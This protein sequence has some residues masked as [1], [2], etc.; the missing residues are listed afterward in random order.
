MTA[1]AGCRRIGRTALR[2]LRHRP[3]A[4]RLAP[5]LVGFTFALTV[6]T[7][8]SGC[9]SS[10]AGTPV[11]PGAGDTPP[12]LAT[13]PAGSSDPSLVAAAGL[14]RCP[15]TSGAAAVD[16]G[17]PDVTL[18]CLA[19]GPPVRLSG[20]RG[21]PTLVN[22]WAS[23]CG[24]CRGELP[25]L[26]R[27]DDAGLR[28][29]GVDLLDHPDAALATLEALDITYPSVQ[30]PGGSLRAELGLVATP[31]TLFVAPDGQIVHV[32]L[33]AFGSDAELAAAAGRYLGVDLP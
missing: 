17:L 4:C 13:V 26:Q 22:I 16:H 30:D 18:A 5:W 3:S 9:G 33:G 1:R 15:T 23:W 27:A 32:K 2:L 20:L 25:M 31:T 29:L 19:D 14:D 11:T 7:S 10:G 12:A 21:R 28:V 24:P 8:V 6:A